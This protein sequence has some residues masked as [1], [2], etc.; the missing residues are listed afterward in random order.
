MVNAGDG[1]SKRD[2][3]ARLNR[4]ATLLY[5]HRPRGLTAQEIA[6][7]VDVSSRT[8]HRDLIAIA[9]ELQLGVSRQNGRWVCEQDNFLPPLKLSLLEA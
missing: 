4:V 5:Q 3:M 2:R 6:R 9:G 7:R 1:F 8:V